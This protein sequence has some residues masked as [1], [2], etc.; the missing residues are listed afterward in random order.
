M[1]SPSFSGE[2]HVRNYGLSTGVSIS[3]SFGNLKSAI[4]KVSRTIENKDLMSSEK[5]EQGAGG[6]A[7]GVGG[8]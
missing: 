2:T 1:S 3:Y 6:A 8:N 7:G 5:K 4:R